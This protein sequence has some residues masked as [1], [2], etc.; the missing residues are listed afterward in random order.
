MVGVGILNYKGAGLTIRCLEH[1]SKL[2]WPADRLEIVVVD[3]ASGDDSLRRIRDA[4]PDVR[5]VVSEVNRG[6]AGGCNLAI[7]S[8]GQVDFVALL[9]N[10]AFVEPGW[11]TPLIDALLD[12]PTAGAA[13]SKI[14]F[15]TT[16]VD[17]EIDSPAF[18]LPGTDMRQLGVR[19]SSVKVG[20][21]ERIQRCHFPDGFWP[22]EAAAQ[23]ELYQRWTDG[24]GVLRVPI[25]RREIPTVCSIRV[26]AEKTKSITIS[27]GDHSLETEVHSRLECVELDVDCT[28]FDM[29]NNAGLELVSSRYAADRGIYQPDRGQLDR[30]D[31]VFAWCG[32]SVVLARSYLDDV[33]L[34]DESLF[35]YYEDFDLSWRGRTLGWTYAY[36]P[37]SV[38]RHSH[39]ATTGEHSDLFNF[40]VERNRLLVLTKNGAFATAVDEVVKV[41]WRVWA[42]VRQDM[43]NRALSSHTKIH[44][45]ALGSFIIHAPMA[46]LKRLSMQARLLGRQIRQDRRR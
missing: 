22:R 20:G 35:L 44:A 18:Q 40:Y 39:A 25:D 24:R 27:A 1:L 42:F 12:D 11:L 16:Y 29:I 37:T 9:N 15:D 8:M 30:P 34:F 38:V 23:N 2:E 28:P 3:N 14:L 26:A 43:Q 32:C 19:V 21:E 7:K 41:G 31:Q 36:V 46:L 13:C 5:V 4:F 33:G 17:F 6:F 45:K 10:D